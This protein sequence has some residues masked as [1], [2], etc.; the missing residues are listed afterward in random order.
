MP[1]KASSLTERASNRA[2]T[3]ATLITS[4]GVIIG[5]IVGAVQWGIAAAL[6]ETNS[7]IDNVS[8]EV[9]SVKLDTMRMQLLMLINDDPTNHEDI[10]KVAK[11]YF[12]DLDGDWVATE[13]FLSWAKAEG[14]DVSGIM[15]VH[16]SRR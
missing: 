16:D 6:S 13:T 11:V 10:L 9:A 1:V 14:V 8:A 4:L 7:K 5:T 2:K 15:A 12:V 3:I